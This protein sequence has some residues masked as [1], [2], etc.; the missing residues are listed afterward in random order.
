MKLLIHPDKHLQHPDIAAKLFQEMSSLQE[1][2]KK[3]CDKDDSHSAAFEDKIAL[4]EDD[5]RSG[6]PN[7]AENLHRFS[8]ESLMD[9]DHRG[10]ALE[11]FVLQ[12]QL[13]TGLPRNLDRVYHIQ[14]A[15]AGDAHSQCQFAAVFPSGSRL[16]KEWMR[17]AA[18]QRYPE[19]MRF[20]G[21]HLSREN[22]FSS[23]AWELLS[24]A[25]ELG[26]KY[27][28][29]IATRAMDGLRELHDISIEAELILTPG[30]NEFDIAFELKNSKD[31]ISRMQAFH[32]VLER[33]CR[34]KD[35]EDKDSMRQIATD[36]AEYV[37][38]LGNWPQART[39]IPE[40]EFLLRLG[41]KESSLD[42]VRGFG[43]SGIVGIE[44]HDYF[45]CRTVVGG[46]SVM[47]PNYEKGR[48][49]AARRGDRG[50]DGRQI[51][52]AVAPF[53]SLDKDA[54]EPSERQLLLQRSCAVLSSKYADQ[55]LS[56]F[57]EG[58]RTGVG[59]ARMLLAAAPSAAPSAGVDVGFRLP[60][61][62][63]MSVVPV[64][65]SS[66]TS[67]VAPEPP[68]SWVLKSIKDIKVEDLKDRVAQ[69]LD[70]HVCLP[71]AVGRKGTKGYKSPSDV[72][73]GLVAVTTDWQTD[74]RNKPVK[75]VTYKDGRTATWSNL[76]KWAKKYASKTP[77]QRKLWKESK[78]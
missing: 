69:Y 43:K 24:Q 22:P 14:G 60:P 27:T 10:A 74:E 56:R 16:W 29:A 52:P 61:P 78:E 51:V 46:Q 68:P 13:G 63:P 33:H 54:T 7:A 21:C 39:L 48:V 75:S 64:V 32:T 5:V 35:S 8:T 58:S 73:L 49:R 59:R 76:A 23:P 45:L 15:V 25:A 6:V 40:R 28:A 57:L 42:R 20:L 3:V 36:F 47:V 38:P 65:S 55:Q 9:D 17:K 44:G 30:I 50:L 1:E 12:L 71:D 31:N 19:A 66:S 18:D 4:F 67:S 11:W 2:Y 62:E 77:K 37:S 53:L 70:I 34:T 41:R 72:M 26:D